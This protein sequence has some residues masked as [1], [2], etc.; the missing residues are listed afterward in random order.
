VG[1]P[2]LQL[3]TNNDA[4]IISR[5][6]LVFAPAVLLYNILAVAAL[7]LAQH[8]FDRKAPIRLLQSMASNP[9]LIACA[10]GLLMTWS[11]I[12]TPAPIASALNLLG[13]TAAPLALVSLGAAIVTYPIKGHILPS[14]ASSVLKLAALPAIVV[15]LT[16][17]LPL[18]TDQRLILLILASTP[19]AVASYVL[20]VKLGGDPALAA[21]TIS[22]STVLSALSLGVVLA[23][24]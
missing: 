13:Q 9:L 17:L 19:T 18:P 10:V 23:L 24:A 12:D 22:I 11:K 15:L 6:V 8:R 20:A 5:A 3:A 1:I 7:T 16:W 21:G 2:V 4:Q 14:I